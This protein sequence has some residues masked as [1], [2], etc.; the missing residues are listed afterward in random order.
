MFF[1]WLK[2]WILPFNYI[3]KVIWKSFQRIRWSCSV[4]QISRNLLLCGKTYY[5]ATYYRDINKLCVRLR[6]LASKRKK[7]CCNFWSTDT[8]VIIIS[9]NSS[10]VRTIKIRGLYNFAVKARRSYP[11][12]RGAHRQTQNSFYVGLLR[13]C[14]AWRMKLSFRGNYSNSNSPVL[15]N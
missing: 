9:D 3:T 7:K 6:K 2:C 11:D 13:G 4:I 10:R 14:F 12:V 5:R 15:L 8:V 1:C